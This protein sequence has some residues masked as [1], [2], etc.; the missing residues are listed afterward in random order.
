MCP[1]PNLAFYMDI[2]VRHPKFNRGQSKWPQ[3]KVRGWKR[4]LS[5]T[6]IQVIHNFLNKHTNK[7][8]WK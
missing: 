5:L 7:E 8:K 2:R 4:H 1:K 6:K 3:E